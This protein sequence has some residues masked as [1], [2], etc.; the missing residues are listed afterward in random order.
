MDATPVLQRVKHGLGEEITAVF[1]PSPFKGSKKRTPQPLLEEFLR[2]ALRELTQHQQIRKQLSLKI[3]T[4]GIVLL[5]TE[6]RTVES[7]WLNDI[8]LTLKNDQTSLSS[9][10]YLVDLAQR[11]I[12]VA[13]NRPGIIE[14]TCSVIPGE[15]DIPPDA[16]Q[17]LVLHVKAQCCEYIT[18]QLRSNPS[19]KISKKNKLLNDP[20]HWEREGRKLRLKISNEH[21]IAP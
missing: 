10:E 4:N 3:D 13:R 9:S 16:R 20:V 11:K 6:A 17:A 14:V 1:L 12:R 15:R 18:K 7:V 21:L 5:P 2:N 19:L 8:P